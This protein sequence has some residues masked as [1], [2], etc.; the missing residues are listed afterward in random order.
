[1]VNLTDRDIVNQEV[2]FLASV[3]TGVDRLEI[4]PLPGIVSIVFSGPDPLVA[5]PT[6]LA[7]HVGETL[8]VPLYLDTAAGLTSVQLALGYDAQ[9]L[10][11]LSVRRGALTGEFPYF[12][13]RHDA[14]AVYV[15]TSGPAL[16]GGA[17]SLIEL[18][19]RVKE[20]AT[21][22][23]ALDLQS[24][25]LNEGHLTIG[26]PPQVG[27]DP[28]D[29]R[30][31]VA[32]TDATSTDTPTFLGGL[33]AKL[34]GIV[35]RIEGWFQSDENDALAVLPSRTVVASEDKPATGTPVID[36][37]GRL[38]SFKLSA[39]EAVAGQLNDAQRWKRDLAGA[40]E[41]ASDPNGKL[42]IPVSVAATRPPATR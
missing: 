13:E 4:P 33:K 16:A 15:D 3:P 7:A 30:I 20:G 37:N 34:D 18:E 24:A 10:D 29:G 22:T 11:V 17:G 14:G 28:T 42:R 35:N 6:D 27:A 12:I 36:L 8:M 5:L 23:I 31:V 38:A 25:A 21:G 39:N 41:P 32:G 19:V 40:T 26:T 1:M 2:E 9:S